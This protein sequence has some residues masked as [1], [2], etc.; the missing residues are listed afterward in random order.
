MLLIPAWQAASMP[1]S[2]SSITTHG[3]GCTPSASAARRKMSGAGF[4]HRAFQRYGQGDFRKP[5][6]PAADGHALH[7]LLQLTECVDTAKQRR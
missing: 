1:V 7:E 6:D 3:E 5:E 2:V 4:S